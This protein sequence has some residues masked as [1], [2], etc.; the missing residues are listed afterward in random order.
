MDYK[1][2]KEQYSNFII[3]RT[4]T[5]YREDLG[6]RET[7]DEAVTRYFDFLSSK[8]PD[9]L[10]F[11]FIKDYS[12]A[13]LA[14][15]NKQIMPSMR[16]LWT[17]GIAANHD[18]VCAFNCSY[19]AI[20]DIRCFHEI[21]YLL[22]NGVGVG[23]SV[24]RQYIVKLPEVSATKYPDQVQCYT[25]ED[26]KEGWSLTYKSLIR[27]WYQGIPSTWDVSKVRPKG[28]LIRGFGG[29]ASGPGVLVDLFNFTKNI[30]HYA[31]G[32]KLNS[33]ELADIICKI[34]D[35]VIAGGVRRSATICTSNLSDQRMKHFKE[36]QFWLENPQR[37]LANI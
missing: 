36:G 3:Q 33:K 32:R 19:I 26:S 16:L 12:L 37:A 2:I 20:S 30:I 8:L 15:R 1:D 5:R 10:P 14:V 34:A 35:I 6:R 29:R 11:D 22:M 27:D 7:W 4:Y 23:F 21:M 24:E 28:T 13:A 9:N 18:P 17:A 31:S 25:V